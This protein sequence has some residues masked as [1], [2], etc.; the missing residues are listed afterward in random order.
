MIAALINKF[1]IDPESG[2]DECDLVDQT[3]QKTLKKTSVP[4]PIIQSL[5]VSLND[6]YTNRIINIPITRWF[7]DGRTKKYETDVIDV[8]LH[9]N[10]I[11]GSVI[12]IEQKGNIINQKSKGNVKLLITVEPNNDFIRDGHNI[13]YHKKIS[14]RDALCGFSFELKHLCGTI[15]K[16]NNRPGCIIVPGFNKIIP[17]FGFRHKNGIGDLIIIFN[18]QFPTHKL[19]AASI[20]MIDQ[21]L[22]I[23]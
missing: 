12:I 1:N 23:L 3:I 19:S 2:E 6:I 16:I 18:V 21:A 13:I 10:I 20:A 22:S 17:R 14:L 15:Y 4:L 5:T 8:E 11:T 9:P 7:M